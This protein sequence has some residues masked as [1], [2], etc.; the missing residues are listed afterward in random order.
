MLLLCH[1]RLLL[2]VNVISAQDLYSQKKKEELFSFY[3]C[4]VGVLV[5]SIMLVF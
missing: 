1:W 3:I 4:T 5:L 2:S